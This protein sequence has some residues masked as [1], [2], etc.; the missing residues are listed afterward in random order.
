MKESG[1]CDNGKDLRPGAKRVNCA[2]LWEF[3]GPGGYS[4]VA[5]VARKRADLTHLLG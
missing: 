2:L 4:P 3:S 1:S 5:F